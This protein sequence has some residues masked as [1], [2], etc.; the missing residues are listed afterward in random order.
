MMSNPIIIRIAAAIENESIF[1]VEPYR[2]ILVGDSTIGLLLVRYPLPTA[3]R[4]SI[5]R[6]KPYRLAVVRDGVI[7]VALVLWALP[8]GGVAELVEIES[9]LGSGMSTQTIRR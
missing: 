9:G 8:H 4:E 1:W 3:E 2:L 6:I 7:E 5:F